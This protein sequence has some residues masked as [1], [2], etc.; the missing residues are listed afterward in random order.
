[1]C[2]EGELS[3]LS[4][5]QAGPAI[6]DSGFRKMCVIS[7]I[8]VIRGCLACFLSLLRGYRAVLSRYKAPPGH[9]ASKTVTKAQG[10][11]AAFPRSRRLCSKI[12]IGRSLPYAWNPLLPV[13]NGTICLPTHF[14]SAIVPFAIRRPLSSG[15]GWPG[16]SG[17]VAF[18][19][20]SKLLNQEDA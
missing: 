19:K 4:P 9:V 14:V 10:K 18:I 2:E 11:L 16:L 15:R 6:E 1:M 17:D 8:S 12:S 13:T 3:E 7:V 20:L 5:K